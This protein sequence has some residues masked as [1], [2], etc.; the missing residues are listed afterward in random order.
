M[1]EG[2]RTPVDSCQE[3]YKCKNCGKII[4][5]KVFFYCNKNKKEV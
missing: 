4:K 1:V 2:V 3:F 5:S